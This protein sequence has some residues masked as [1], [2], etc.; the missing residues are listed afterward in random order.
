MEQNDKW[1]IRN[2]QGDLQTSTRLFFMGDHFM[3][4]LYDGGTAGG[5][6]IHNNNASLIMMPNAP[7]PTSPAGACCT[8][9]LRWMPTLTDAAGATCLWGR[10]AT[11]SSLPGKFAENNL[12]PTVSGNMFRWEIR[13]ETH[14]R[15]RNVF[16]RA[17]HRRDGHARTGTTQQTVNRLSTGITFPPSPTERDQD[18]DKRHQ[19]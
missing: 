15:C 2:Y 14:Q 3:D 4:T 16:D 6:I 10:Q 18:L 13:Q 12:P 19:V 7:P 5:N 11:R 8:S 9:R 17:R 1:T